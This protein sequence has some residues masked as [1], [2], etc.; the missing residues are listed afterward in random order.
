MSVVLLAPAL[1]L[2]AGESLWLEKFKST[3]NIWFKCMSLYTQFSLNIL[4]PCLY[5]GKGLKVFFS[6]NL[7]KA[8]PLQLI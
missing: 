2:E 3:Y 1:S 4:L 7:D 6:S 8:R 5:K